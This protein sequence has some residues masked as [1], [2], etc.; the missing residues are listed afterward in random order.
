VAPDLV[1]RRTDAWFLDRGLPQ[2]IADYRASTDIW[3][4]ALPALTL[5]FLAELVGL[6]P[7][8]S[9]PIWLDVLVVAGIFVLATGAWAL[10]NRRRGRAPLARPDDV[11]PIEIAAFVV[12]PTIVPLVFGGQLRQAVLTG[13][14]NAL[15]V[16]AIYL[17]TSYA[18]IAITRWG[19]SRLTRQLEAI[20]S[21]L[22]RALPMIALLVT[23]L[24]LTQ[25]VWAT[26]GVLDGAPYW[27]AALLFPLVGTVFLIARLPRDIGELN[28]FDAR[29]ELASLIDGTPI[30][31]ATDVDFE[32][33]EP[34]PLGR[35]EW[36]N[37]GLVAL[38]SQGVQIAIV[39]V[40][41]GLF[42]VVLGLLL[43][44]ESATQ[45]FAGQVKVLATLSLGARDLVVTEELLRV[46]GFLTAFSGLNFTVYLVTDPTYRA[47]FREEVVSELRQ[48]FAVRA[49][50][51][52]HLDE[53][54]RE[55]EPGPSATMPPT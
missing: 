48:A 32:G 4:R 10:L 28:R 26:A 50:Y 40:L 36:G 30:A 6:A 29:D 12:V 5:L 18:L 14:A 35:R 46:A 47:E 7:N 22:A 52:A 39:S 42:F 55:E 21:L 38:F 17:V 9:F 11:G 23:F 37:V 3:T 2:F 8:R 31:A 13:L 25:E 16:G 20:V 33:C 41:I 27:L 24:F 45:T 43:V 44:D 1:T 53:Q 54:R 15:I 34:P 19:A 51:R 49:V